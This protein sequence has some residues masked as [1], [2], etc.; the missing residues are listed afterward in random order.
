MSV[1]RTVLDYVK[2]F[3]ERKFKKMMYP[4]YE[5]EFKALAKLREAKNDL[6][7]KRIGIGSPKGSIGLKIKPGGSVHDAVKEGLSR[8]KEDRDSRLESQQLGSSYKGSSSR[9]PTAMRGRSIDR[10]R[11]IF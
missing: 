2:H 7:I 4:E 3:D 9:R 5:K 6:K 11:Q 1:F 10:G 8:L